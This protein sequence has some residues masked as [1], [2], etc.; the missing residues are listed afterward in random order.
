MECLM[1][2]F[3]GKAH[4]KHLE[5]LLEDPSVTFNARQFFFY[6]LGQLANQ[7]LLLATRTS[8]TASAELRRIHT[9]Q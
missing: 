8:L 9:L 6:L 2:P 5:K 3:G 1:Y 4:G 7:G